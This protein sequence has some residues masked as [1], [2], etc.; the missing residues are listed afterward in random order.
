MTGDT[1]TLDAG[2]A[3]IPRRR[4]AR[5]LTAMVAASTVGFGVYAAIP[6]S[7]APSTWS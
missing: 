1:T 2:A 3:R 4:L 5:W 7:A 6:A